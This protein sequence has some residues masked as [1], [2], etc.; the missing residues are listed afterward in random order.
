MRAQLSSFVGRG[1]GAAAGQQGAGG[2]Q[3]GD[4]GG[5][6]GGAGKTRLALE[7]AE[8][9]DGDVCLVQLAP[10]TADAEVA[11]A[12]LAALGIR[13][14]HGPELPDPVERLVTALARPGAAAHPG[15]QRAR[16]G[17]GREAGRHAA[18]VLPG[19]AGAGHEQGGAGHHRRVAGAGVAAA[20][21][22]AR[23]AGPARLPGGA[24][25]RRPGGG[26]AARVRGHPRERRAGGPHLPRPGRPAAGDRAGGGP[27][28]ARCR[29]RR[30]RRG[31]TTGS[32]CWR[33]AAGRRCRAT[34]RCARWWRGAGTC[35]TRT[36]SGWPDG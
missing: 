32:G 6:A 25:V 5:G 11:P 4:V 13:D 31:W 20:A 1:G 10:V 30:W 29:W 27:G 28:C 9:A 22:A 16:G 8:R 34:R 24:A 3:V 12:V 17:G 18:R 14:R 33:A 19:A 7:V 21:A 35:W 23:R 15:Q 2:V 36:S 26:R